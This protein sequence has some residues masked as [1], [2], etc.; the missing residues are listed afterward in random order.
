[1]GQGHI[2]RYIYNQAIETEQSIFLRMD[3]STVRATAASRDEI[4]IAIQHCS[5]T[6][7][8]IHSYR[9]SGEAQTSARISMARSGNEAIT[10]SALMK[11]NALG[12]L[13]AEKVEKGR[14]HTPLGL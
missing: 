1:M 3:S 8:P 13:L 4:Q 5:T 7:I 6:S 11:D 2:D 10:H 9:R 12:G 14:F